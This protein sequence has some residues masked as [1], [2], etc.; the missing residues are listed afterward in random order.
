MEL[1]GDGLDQGA[2]REDVVVVG[3][4]AVECAR[5][6]QLAKGEVHLVEDSA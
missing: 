4:L 3:G 1:E 6:I 5:Q 2:L